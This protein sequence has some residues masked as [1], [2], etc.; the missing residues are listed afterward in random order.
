MDER[1]VLGQVDAVLSG[2]QGAEDMGLAILEA[3]A[4]VKRRNPSALYCCDP[5]LGDTDRGLYVRPGIPALMRERVV[6]AAQVITP[7]QFELAA[8]TG[9]PT[10]SQAEVLAAADAARA[11]G[12]DTVLVT[13]VVPARR[14][15]RDHRHARGDRRRRL[16]RRHA[17]AAA[18]LHRRRGPHRSD[19]PGR[20]AADRTGAAGSRSGPPRWSSAC[21]G[22]PTSWAG[23]SS[24]WSPPSTRSR[25]RSALRPAQTP[26]S[27]PTAG[28][29]SPGTP[30]CWRPARSAGWPGPR[31]RG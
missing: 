27:E 10:G 11:L 18:D 28:R 16:A 7:N 8:L 19:L 22:S 24:P 30:R 20:A 21:C 1:G 12:P 15:A 4:L 13:S 5:V 6:P 26:L 9:L 2:Y 14:R 17:A 31:S 3:V 23:P 25:T 29:L